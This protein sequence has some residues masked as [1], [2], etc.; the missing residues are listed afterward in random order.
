MLRPL[1]LAAIFLLVGCATTTPEKMTD[2]QR[3]GTEILSSVRQ[4][5]EE[6]KKG[7]DAGEAQA[8][9]TLSETDL[10]FEFKDQDV[11]RKYAVRV[12]NMVQAYCVGSQMTTGKWQKYSWVFEKERESYVRRC[13]DP[14]APE[15]PTEK[16]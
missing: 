7:F 8:Y 2:E 11:Y 12:S 3:V 13:R 15:N 9:C 10:H 5:C 16:Q 1:T 14:K 4:S 6:A